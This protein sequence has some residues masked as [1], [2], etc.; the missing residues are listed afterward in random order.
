MIIVS[1]TDARASFQDIV[2]RAE[3]GGERVL[4][5]RH[6]KTVA[7]VISIGDLKRLE[8]MEDAIDSEILRRAVKENDGFTS[9]DSIIASRNDGC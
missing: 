4:I 2:R 9:L 8:A 3:Y 5:Q 7:A 6:S 1:A